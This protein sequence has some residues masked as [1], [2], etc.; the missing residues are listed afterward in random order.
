MSGRRAVEFVDGATSDLSFV[1]RGASREA[2][3]GAASE[4][5][6][7]AT[8]ENP[9]A[10]E[11][12]IEEVVEL[13]EPDAELLLLAFLNELVYLRDARGWLLRAADLHIED[14][15]HGVT[16]RGRLVGEEI[17]RS[18]HRLGAD[19]KAATAHGLKLRSDEGGW[20]AT[21]TLDV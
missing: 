14:E 12:R 1:A 16:L 15:A 13:C 10:V 3:F 20:E 9:E 11:A 19:V 17:D 4:A 18:R 5:L 7:Q 2:A 6:L 8:V 21:V